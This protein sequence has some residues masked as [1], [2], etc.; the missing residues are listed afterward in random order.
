MSVKR[1]TAIVTSLGAAGTA[2]LGSA[3]FSGNKCVT[4]LALALIAL[5]QLVDNTTAEKVSE[6]LHNGTF[7]KLIREALVK[8]AKDETVPQLEIH[9]EEDSA[10]GRQDV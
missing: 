2:L 6:S 1:V 3:A 4:G 7:E 9:R 5:S 8:L 10:N